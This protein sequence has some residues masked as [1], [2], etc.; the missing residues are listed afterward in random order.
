MELREAKDR[1]DHEHPNWNSSQK[2][3]AISEIRDL[4]GDPN[5]TKPPRLHFW[6]SARRAVVNGVRQGI[7]QE[8]QA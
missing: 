1:I 7:E 3:R 2:I 8:R 5:W 4:P 6:R